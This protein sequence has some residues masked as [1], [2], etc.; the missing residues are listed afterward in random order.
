MVRDISR[1]KRA[2]LK[3]ENFARQL[4]ALSRRLAEVE[5][6]ERKRIARELHDQVG[7][8]LATVNVNL[9]IVRAQLD[10]ATADKVTARL[11]DSLG[12]VISTIEQVRNL[13][14]ELRPPVLDDYGLAAALRWYGGQ[15]GE[16]TGIAVEVRG[17][18]LAPRLASQVETALFRIAQEALNNVLKHARATRV[19]IT[20]EQT[21][22]A[23]SITF[24]DNGVGFDAVAVTYKDAQ[25]HWGLSIMRERAEGAGAMFSVDTAPGCGTRVTVLIRRAAS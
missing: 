7:Q 17:A 9:S 21:P 22:E 2:E 15:Y 4:Q 1:S 18:E 24:A 3:V 5:E 6:N 19:D 13:M 10:P 25:P 14:A 23:F 12:L 11:D 8:N 20:L 16:R